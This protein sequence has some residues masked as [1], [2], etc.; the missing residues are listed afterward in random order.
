MQPGDLL[1]GVGVPEQG[2]IAAGASDH[3][4]P[5]AA[6]RSEGGPISLSR[7]RHPDREVEQRP[8]RHAGS[9][10]ADHIQ[11]V[12]RP[13]VDAGQENAQPIEAST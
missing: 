9:T 11:R 6:G 4:D 10:A 1:E 13:E 7:L 2:G 3:R 5:G 12:V 8:D